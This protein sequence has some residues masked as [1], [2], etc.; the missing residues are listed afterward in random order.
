[1]ATSDFKA[2]RIRGNRFILSGSSGNEPAF[3]IYSASV[4]N[5]LTGGIKSPARGGF[6]PSTIGD[7]VFLVVSGTSGSMSRAAGNRV[8]GTMVFIGD[9][10]FSGA[11]KGNIVTGS[12]GPT[13]PRGLQGLTGSAPPS[14]SLASNALIFSITPSGSVTSNPSSVKITATYVSQSDAMVLADYKASGSDGSD[15][16]GRLSGF[17]NTSTTSGG[18]VTGASSIVFSYN[19]ADRTRYPIFVT[20]SSDTFTESIAIY[21]VADGTQGPTGSQGVQGIQGLQG[22]TGSAVPSLDLSAN[23][24]I[25]SIIPSG[26]ATSNPTSIKITATYVSQ[27]NAMTALDFQVSGSDGTNLSGSRFSAF[28]N[29]STTSGGKVTGEASIVFSYNNADRTRYPVFVTASSD[30]FTKSVSIYRVTEG[31]QGEQ[32]IQG[33]QGVQG[34]TGSAPPSLSLASNALIFSITPSGS[35]TSNPASVKITATYVSQS[36]AMTALDFQVSGSDG[37]NLSG[38]RFSAF[39]NT[40]TTS[41]G[42]VTGEASI[43]FSYNNADRTRYPVFVTASS[44]SFT[45]SIAIYRVADGTQ[46]PTGSQG[47][48]GIQGVQGPSG[49]DGIFSVTA[50]TG[51]RGETTSSVAFANPVGDADSNTAGFGKGLNVFFYV[52][53]SK[54]SS[55]MPGSAAPT[56]SALFGGD[57]VVSGTLQALAVPGGMFGDTSLRAAGSITATT[58]VTSSQGGFIS[59]GFQPSSIPGL[60]GSI[61]RTPT[62]QAFI[63]GDSSTSVAYNHTTRQWTIG[64]VAATLDSAYDGGGAAAGAIINADIYP[65]QINNTVLAD[66]AQQTLL[67]VSGVATFGSA[68]AQYSGHMPPLPG[69]D[70]SFFVSGSVKP[71]PADYRGL[72]NTAVF[73][74]D[75]LYSGSIGGALRASATGSNIEVLRTYSPLHFRAKSNTAVTTT[76]LILDRSGS[77]SSTKGGTRI[78]FKIPYDNTSVPGAAIEGR[79]DSASSTQ[80][81]GRLSFYTQNSTTKLD[82]QMRIGYEGVTIR[83]G[84]AGTVDAGSAAATLLV[85]GGSRPRAF[86]VRKSSGDVGIGLN[87]SHALHVSGAAIQLEGPIKAPDG[88]NAT[89]AKIYNMNGED[90]GALDIYE[91]LAAGSQANIRLTPRAGTSS[92]ISG[93]GGI[94]LGI[95][96]TSPQSNLEIVQAKGKGPFVSPQTV[97]NYG[98][99]IRNEG[100][101]TGESAGIGFGTSTNNI[102]ASI[103]FL[104]SGSYA[105]GDLSFYTKLSTASGNAPVERMRIKSTGNIGIGTDDPQHPLDIL[106]MGGLVLGY[107]RLNNGDAASNVSYSITT[108]YA[109]PNANWKTTFTAPKSGKVEIQFSCFLAS[110]ASSATKVYLGLSSGSTYSSIGNLH[111][112]EV[113]ET[114]DGD[115]VTVNHSWVLT[116]L[117]PGTSYTYY[118]G[119][120]AGTGS[121]Q[122]WRYGGTNSNL[123]QDL[124]I[125][126]ISLPD[127]LT[128]D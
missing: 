107:T 46:G 80:N 53:G 121:V 27:S 62:G 39:S 127:T 82:E 3:M 37:T 56:G 113:W 69:I 87:P 33:I 17:S 51:F 4:A 41:G 54:N 64:A 26:S 59:Y 112:R 75:V 109:V 14:L 97:G 8:R 15:L 24:L 71:E 34:L 9:V 55:M 40:S 23:A 68:S 63:A 10:Y 38:S 66:G 72:I 83:P 114:D 50:G 6:I 77:V 120:K 108:S 117:T 86:M 116:G 58:S 57:L 84:Y 11:M 79:K 31:P 48:Q 5:D 30:S 25:F 74:G 85:H 32:G 100:T 103:V 89:L 60:T 76:A 52:S 22:L 126:T 98:L 73:G 20:A 13:G 92:Y 99:I 19:N 2:D 119:T 44:D 115:N 35:L 70:T 16:S 125:R 7:D 47:I 118:I 42:K 102:G 106:E 36:N 88:N 124:I 123:Y 95:N 43:V 1:M 105:K 111:Q 122:F 67:A 28:S 45:E 78:L 104:D 18:K 29:T 12:D 65:V 94:K 110:A 90:D 21:R 61:S 49:G 91:G 101:D 128:T 81:Y 96:T 93:S